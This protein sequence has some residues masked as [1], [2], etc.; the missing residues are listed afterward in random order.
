MEHVLRGIDECDVYIDGIGCFDS[1]WEQQLATLHKVLTR[2]QDN[3]FSINPRKCEWAVQE[4][5]FLGY[6]LTPTGLKPW[7]KKINAI[8][9][10]APPKM[11]KDLRTFIGAVTFYRTMFPQQAHLLAPLTSLTSQKKGPIKWQQEHQT[12]FDAVKALLAANVLLRYPDHN[13]PFHVY[14]NASNLQLGAVIVQEQRPVAYYSRKLNAAQRNYTT[15]EKELLSIVETLK[16]F[17]TMLYGCKEL[18]V[19]TDH[20]NLTSQTLNS[21]RVLRWLLF[22]EEFGPIFHYLQGTENSLADALS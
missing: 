11:V 7:R 4:T 19:Y 20:K 1:S 8:L 10:L 3:N 15:M 18:H 21:Q 14:S 17:R 13:L 22:L 12:A 16:E 9:E 5:D 2:L 6:W